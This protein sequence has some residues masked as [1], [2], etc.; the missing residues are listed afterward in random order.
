MKLLIV[1]DNPAVR[2]MIKTIVGGLADEVYECEDGDEALEAYQ[3]QR[4]DVVL[5]DIGLGRVDGITA[6]RRITAADPAAYV[7]IVTS[8]DGTDLRAAAQA[9]G[10]CGYVLKENLLEL[11]RLLQPA[12]PAAGPLDLE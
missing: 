2:R 9:A 8:Y 11:R 6:T 3:T 12:A 7:I 5:M 4:P 10:A 1:E